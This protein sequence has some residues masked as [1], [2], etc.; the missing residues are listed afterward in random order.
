MPSLMPFFGAW[1]DDPFCFQE[2]IFA[3]LGVVLTLTLCDVSTFPVAFSH[4]GVADDGDIG[5][6]FSGDWFIAATAAAAPVLSIVLR[7]AGVS[8]SATTA[9]PLVEAVDAPVPS[10]SFRCRSIPAATSVVVSKV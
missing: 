5:E 3:T 10:M 2:I 9:V 7:G 4:D 1:S 6:F 8:G